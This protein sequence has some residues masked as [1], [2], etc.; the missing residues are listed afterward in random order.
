VFT[1]GDAVFAGTLSTTFDGPS[2]DGP[3]VGIAANPVGPGYLIATSE[4][5]IIAYGGAS[6]YGSPALSGINPAEPIVAIQYA[7]DGTGYWAV[8]ADGGIFTYNSSVTVGTGSKA[9]LQTTGH[10]GYFGSVPAEIGA[11]GVTIPTIVGIA[12]TL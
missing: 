6:F 4:G 1:Y 5:N 10:A 7:P 11:S 2:P 12:P 3:A 8:G 9:T